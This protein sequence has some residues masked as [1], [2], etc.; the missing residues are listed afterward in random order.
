MTAPLI[1]WFRR[2]LRLTD[3]LALAAAA[4]TGAPLVALFILDEDDDP[5]LG[6]AARWWLHHSLVSLTHDLRERGLSLTLRRGPSAASLTRLVPETGARAVFWSRVYEPA[7]LR[8]DGEIE[9]MLRASGVEAQSFSG[10][11]LFEPGEI[12]SAQGRA[13]RVF[14]PFWRAAQAIVAPGAPKP[15]PTRLRAAPAPRSERL[16]DWGLT[17]REPDWAGGLR[18]AWRPGESGARARLDAFVEDGVRD[19]AAARD[20]PAKDNVSR[21]SPHLHWGEIGP[22]QVW[23]AIEGADAPR[24]DIAAFLRELGWR[25]FCHHILLDHPS[26]PEAPLDPDF[27]RFPWAQDDGTLF[28]A[29]A[30]GA[31]GYPFVDAGMRQLWLTGWMHNRLRMIV[32]SFL[33]KHLLLDWREGERWFFDT[34]VDADLSSNAFN[35]QWAA[36][37]GADAAPYFRIFNP[38]LQGEKYDAD[39]AFVRRFVP[40]LARLDAHYIHRPWTAPE[41]K[42]REA[43][44]RL[45]ET[46]PLAIIDLAAARRRALDAFDSCRRARRD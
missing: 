11:L 8:R 32:A 35:W 21:L 41:Q 25:E 26:L 16:E 18:D 15:A 34:L 39:G 33:V 12:R 40:E 23:R 9:T 46:Y 10:A 45:G 38:V 22:R 2:D 1:L 4:T 17:P 36:G 6:G 37:C 19:Y 24:A 43:G 3:N 5:P 42:L 28:R 14:A 29:W 44:V 27:A 30:R 13:F 20:F 7:A 31:T